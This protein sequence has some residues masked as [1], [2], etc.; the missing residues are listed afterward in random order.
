MGVMTPEAP[1]VVRLPS[2]GGL[3]RLSGPAPITTSLA[4]CLSSLRIREILP[5]LDVTLSPDARTADGVV[6]GDRIWS[7]ALTPGTLV[8]TLLGQIV[9]TLTTLLA[10][11][12]FVHAGAVGFD[13]RGM[14]LVGESGAGK[15]STVAALLRRGATY[16]SDEVALLDPSAGAVMPFAVPMAV[17]PWTRKAAGALP[18]GRAVVRE[19][20]VEFW[21]PN[22][23]EIRPIEV[24]TFVLLRHAGPGTR[25]SPIS[26]ASL[27]LALAQHISSF[28]QRHRL[29]QAFAGFTRLLRNARCMVLETPRPAAR[30][31]LLATFGRRS[32]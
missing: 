2:A 8:G 28:K 10:E 17:K 3:V 15:T 5:I 26:R 21:L 31:D 4:E 14:I 18:P 20:D 12:L 1:A 19:G 11:S 6:N 25:L 9:G 13:G 23:R 32:G 30:A 16:L 27:L 22:D 24:D 29:P 7:V